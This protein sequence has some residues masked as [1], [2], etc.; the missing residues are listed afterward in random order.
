MQI[1]INF[2]DIDLYDWMDF[3]DSGVDAPELKDIEV[4][5]GIKMRCRECRYKKSVRGIHSTRYSCYCKHPN[6]DY[7]RHYYSKNNINR[8][9][10]FICFTKPYTMEMSIKTSPK[11]CPLKEEKE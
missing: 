1:V 9:L 6:Q 10:G 7:I 8:T 4:Q 11:W 3:D 2:Y 5:G